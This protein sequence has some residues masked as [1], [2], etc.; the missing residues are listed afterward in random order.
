MNFVNLQKYLFEQ[1][2]SRREL[3]NYISSESRKTYTVYVYRNH[4]FELVEHTIKAY[5]DYAQLNISF[6]YS[7]Y[8]DSISFV[9]INTGADVILLWI[10]FSRYHVHDIE[11]FIKRRISYLRSIFRKHILVAPLNREDFYCSEPGV[12][13]IDMK[14]LKNQLGRKYLDERLEEFSGTK[15]SNSAL[16]EMTK[17]LAL[18]YFPALLK[19]PVKAIVVDL[20]NTI[21]NGVL[22]EDGIDRIVLTEEHR[23]FQQLLVDLSKQGIFICV[24]SKNDPLDVESLFNRR[25]DFPL[26]RDMFTKVCASW[27]PKSESIREIIHFINIHEESVLFIDDNIGEIIEVSSVFPS[28]KVIQASPNVEITKKVLENFPGVFRLAEMAE[29]TLRKDDVKANKKR[30]ELKQSVSFDEYVRSLNMILTYKVNNFHDISRIA[31]LANKTNQFIFFYKRYSVAEINEY[32]NM[33]QGSCSVISIFLKDNLSDSGLIGACVVIKNGETAILDDFFVSCRALGRGIDDIIVMQ[34][35]KLAM[36][37]IEA[38][39]LKVNFRIGER[40]TPAGLFIDKY[41]K[42]YTVNSAPFEY[43]Y[44]QNLLEVKIEG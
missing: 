1:Q 7:N 34:A 44:E 41:L 6:E 29:D 23:K 11:E 32:M 10:D 42:T 16:L 17:A 35:I 37:R 38:D 8:D 28:I 30:E 2:P 27:A 21:Y 39:K 15:L 14:L 24:V 31:E 19:Q 3:I 25:T 26:K 5:L 36:M 4:S 9:D 12:F 33:K 22:G 40:N 13:V 43:Q 18:K 20:D